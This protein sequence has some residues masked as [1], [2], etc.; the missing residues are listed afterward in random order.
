MRV[1]RC[2]A[3]RCPTERATGPP[4][5]VENIRAPLAALIRKLEQAS[6]LA[7]IGFVGENGERVSLSVLSHG[8]TIVR[9]ETEGDLGTPPAG[10]ANSEAVHFPSERIVEA[11]NEM[12]EGGTVLVQAE[13]DDVLILWILGTLEI[14][15][16]PHA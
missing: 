5:M 1:S 8:R 4:A 14:Y 12:M 10:A 3:E 6:D 2:G 13:T 7:W 16:L 9:I 15:V 11:I